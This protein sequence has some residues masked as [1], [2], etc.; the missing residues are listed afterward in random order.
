VEEGEEEQE[1]E[2]QEEQEEERWWEAID[3]PQPRQDGRVE[4]GGG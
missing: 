1:E 2:E 3:E 4:F